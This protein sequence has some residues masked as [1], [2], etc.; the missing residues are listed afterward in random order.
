[1]KKSDLAPKIGNARF[2][3]LKNNRIVI[4]PSSQFKSDQRVLLDAT[5]KQI[6][7]HPSI[8][9]ISGRSHIEV[10]WLSIQKKSSGYYMASA[11]IKKAFPNTHIDQMKRIL[12]SDGISA[13]YDDILGLNTNAIRMINSIKTYRG[14]AQG[15]PASS[16]LQARYLSKALSRFTKFRPYDS[17]AVWV[18]DVIFFSKT[19]TAVVKSIEDFSWQ[20]KKLDNISKIHKTNQKAP[21]IFGPDAVW[22]VLGFEIG[23]TMISKKTNEEPI[24][25]HKNA[26]HLLNSIKKL[27]E[28]ALKAEDQQVLGKLDELLPTTP[29]SSIQPTDK[30][31]CWMKKGF[32]NFNSSYYYTSRGQRNSTHFDQRS[33]REAAGVGCSSTFPSFAQ[34]ELS[35][36]FSIDCQKMND[37]Y[38]QFRDDPIRYS[39]I[40]IHLRNELWAFFIAFYGSG[41]LSQLWHT[42]KENLVANYKTRNPQAVMEIRSA[43]IDELRMID[44]GLPLRLKPVE[45]KISDESLKCVLRGYVTSLMIFLETNR[46]KALTPACEFE[47]G[48]FRYPTLGFDTTEDFEDDFG[49]LYCSASE[50]HDLGE[51]ADIFESGIGDLGSL[52]YAIDRLIERKKNAS[53]EG[54]FVSRMR[55]PVGALYYEYFESLAIRS[56]QL[57][58]QSRM[59]ACEATYFT[60]SKMFSEIA[61]RYGLQFHALKDT[62]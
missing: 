33:S 2:C 30:S 62:L 17:I 3:I 36:G 10:L 16:M 34:T 59:K 11:D 46:S 8:Y 25:K 22:P 14:L 55:E 44:S 23:G 38:S 27:K 13:I 28:L 57:D 18:D 43:Y 41:S 9:S 32:P 1:M 21:K 31:K 56:N 15:L 29:I 35:K 61:N 60:S 19:R 58:L 6:K 51:I 45:L 42:N 7:I 40:Y 47:V 5:S 52:K 20:L 4:A 24:V 49:N 54:I 48:R 26:L 37:W 53:L 50:I 39:Q 12:R